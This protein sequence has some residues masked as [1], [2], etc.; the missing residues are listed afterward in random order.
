MQ[1]ILIIVL[2]LFQIEM[3]SAQ[4][5]LLFPGSVPYIDKS[6]NTLFLSN[7]TAEEI[8][9][10]FMSLEALPFKV[11]AISEGH[12]EGYRLVYYQGGNLKG[13]KFWIKIM[14]VNTPSCLNYFEEHHPELLMRPFESLKAQI[15]FYNHSPG[16]FKKVYNHYKYLSCRLYRQ[17]LDQ[18]GATTDEMSTL[19]QQYNDTFTDNS[20]LM[21]GQNKTVYPLA[22]PNMLPVNKWNHF[23]KLIHAIDGA[24]YTTLIEYS[25]VLN[26]Y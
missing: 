5:D 7:R 24:S 23:M 20:K 22:R 8:K 4:P 25:E 26:N 17:T 11:T 14:M 19:I 12:Y 9:S 15:G 18:S 10:Y 3:V 16:D 2:M 13:R 21:A 1:R 6:D